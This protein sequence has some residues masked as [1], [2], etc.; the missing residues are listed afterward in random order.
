MRWSG[1]ILFGSDIVTSDAHVSS[2][3]NAS[4]MEAKAS[5]AEEAYD[6][7]ASRYWAL[8]TLIE[9][10]HEGE[11]PIAD[12]D[13]HLVSPDRHTPLDAPVL[14]GFSLPERYLDELYRGAAE[15]LLG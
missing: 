5:N 6:L 9:T 13:L 4:E 12:P 7:Y 3:S 15:K 8:R 11:S 2:Q 1:R 10:S 14:R